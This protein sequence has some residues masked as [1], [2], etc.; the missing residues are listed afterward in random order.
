M[1]EQAERYDRHRGVCHYSVNERPDLKMFASES[2]GFIYSMIVLQHIKP[3]YQR[4]YLKEF[5]RVLAP[6]GVLVFQLPSEPIP[7]RSALRGRL[8]PIIKSITPDPVLGAYRRVRWGRG[9]NTEMW[10]MPK[11]DVIS[12]LQEEGARI[13]DVREDTS[14]GK[15]WAGFRY[16]VMKQRKRDP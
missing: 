7:R 13:L 2:F 11:G 9:S 3:R 14:A 10:G 15:N 5:V 16:A 1:I 4:A 8:K 12:L 6:G